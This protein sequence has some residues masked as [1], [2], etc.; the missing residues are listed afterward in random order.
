MFYNGTCNDGAG[1]N[2]EEI[3]LYLNFGQGAYTCS[4]SSIGIIKQVD[5]TVSVVVLD[6]N[7]G[8]TKV[9]T[10]KLFE[11]TNDWKEPDGDNRIL[12]NIV[13]PN[14]G[15]SY[16]ILIQGIVECSRCVDCPPP[17]QGRQ[18]YFVESGFEPNPSRTL[19]LNK[20]RP[21]CYPGP[22]VVVDCL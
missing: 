14:D 22:G 17:G 15:T 19:Y 18:Y 8:A 1:A 3:D 21:Q 11:K 7:T 13:V 10:Q 4:Y 6:P 9:Y 20:M 5:Y 12:E 16:Q 2:E